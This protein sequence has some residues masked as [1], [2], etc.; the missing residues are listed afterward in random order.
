MARVLFS[1]IAA[2]KKNKFSSLVFVFVPTMKIIRSFTVWWSSLSIVSLSLL[3]LQEQEDWGEGEEDD[4]RVGQRREKMTGEC[5]RWLDPVSTPHN[6][7]FSL[8]MFLTINE[9]RKLMR[10]K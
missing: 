1:L 9:R 8:R 7:L 10:I 5:H 3:F 2:R 6:L 4:E